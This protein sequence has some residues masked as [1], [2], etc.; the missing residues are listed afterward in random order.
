L[1]L[2]LRYLAVELG[3]EHPKKVRNSRSAG[4]HEFSVGQLAWRV[5][6]ALLEDLYQNLIGCDYDV[7][8]DEIRGKLGVTG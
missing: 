8:L 4:R 6:T 1:H 2:A 7:R 5:G 3:F